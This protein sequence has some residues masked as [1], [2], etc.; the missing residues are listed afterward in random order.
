MTRKVAAAAGADSV[1]ISDQAGA[2]GRPSRF[3]T[4][5]PLPRWSATVPP[6]VFLFL[7]MPNV[8]HTG[9]MP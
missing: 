4:E 8:N 3:T 7:M 2:K 6:A 9:R 1:S 5:G